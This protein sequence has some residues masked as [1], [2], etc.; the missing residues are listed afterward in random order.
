[1]PKIAELFLSNVTGSIFN[2][3]I[4]N[5]QIDRIFYIKNPPKSTILEDFWSECH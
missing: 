5:G 4:K 2:R 3:K 1:M